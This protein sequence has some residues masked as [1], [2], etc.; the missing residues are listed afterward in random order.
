LI[1]QQEEHLTH[2]NFPVIPYGYLLRYLTS[3][4]VTLEKKAG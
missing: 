1:G 3:V 2:K 4:G